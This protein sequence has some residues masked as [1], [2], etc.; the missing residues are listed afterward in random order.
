M[1]KNVG[2]EAQRPGF[3][4]QPSLNSCVSPSKLFQFSTYWL[5]CL[6]K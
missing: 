5:P 2:V 3:D 1:S 6:N 4:F